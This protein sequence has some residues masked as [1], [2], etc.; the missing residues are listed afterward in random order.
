MRFSDLSLSFLPVSPNS[1]YFYEINLLA[2][3]MSRIVFLFLSRIANVI[4]WALLQQ[5][6]WPPPYFKFMTNETSSFVS[7][8]MYHIRFRNDFMW[9]KT[10]ETKGG[11]GGRGGKSVCLGR[12]QSPSP[13]SYRHT[14]R[15]REVGTDKSALE[16]DKTSQMYE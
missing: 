10:A 13:V 15:N 9:R 8:R 6:S 1:D 5:S 2:Y 16:I 7:S 12:S 3:K 4:H 14:W 11:G